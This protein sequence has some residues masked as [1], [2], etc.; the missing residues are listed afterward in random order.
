MLDIIFFGLL[1]YSLGILTTIGGILM[2]FKFAF[3]RMRRMVKK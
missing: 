2:V 3:K 1:C